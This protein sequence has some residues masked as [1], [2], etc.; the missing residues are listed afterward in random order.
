MS[1]NSVVLIGRLTR[2]PELKY[3]P[4]GT[5]VC[6]MSI[7]VNRTFSK[8]D[9]ADFFDVTCWKKTA[10]ATAQHMKK[11]RQIA[12]QGELR[13]DRWTTDDGKNRSKVKVNAQQVR[14]LGGN[15]KDSVQQDVDDISEEDLEIDESDMPF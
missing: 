9:E 15:N 5:A 6:N 12:V 10:E 14:F 11:G 2:D 13:Q 1:L 8:E 3:T 4:N 7:A